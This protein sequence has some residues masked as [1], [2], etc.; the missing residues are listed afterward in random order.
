[1]AYDHGNVPSV[2]YHDT[3]TVTGLRDGL[4]IADPD[5]LMYR[6]WNNREGNRS[7]NLPRLGLR[8]E[9]SS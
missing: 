9:E 8:Q 5:L 4:G 7:I 3:I 2:G 6:A 1:M